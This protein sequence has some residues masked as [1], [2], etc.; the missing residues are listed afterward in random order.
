METL[1]LLNWINT[2]DGLNKT[3]TSLDDLTDGT[4]LFEARRI[5]QRL[6][7]AGFPLPSNYRKSGIFL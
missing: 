3:P 2:F 7:P 4:V 1:S 6:D 5:R